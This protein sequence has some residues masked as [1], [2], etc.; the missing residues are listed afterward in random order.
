MKN[1]HNFND[2]PRRRRVRKR[3]L[4]S[5]K[6]CLNAMSASLCSLLGVV[7]EITFFMLQQ[8]DSPNCDN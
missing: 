8:D 1:C 3:F 7:G 2:K 6:H 5:E 4:S